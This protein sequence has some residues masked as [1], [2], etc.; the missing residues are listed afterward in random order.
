VCGGRISPK[1]LENVGWTKKMFEQL[2]T[3]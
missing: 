1:V 3:S 2:L